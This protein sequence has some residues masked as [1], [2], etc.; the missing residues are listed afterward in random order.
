MRATW[1][2]IVLWTVDSGVARKCALAPRE[3][4]MMSEAF[5]IQVESV[6]F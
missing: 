6:Q 1:G 2:R 4:A 3:S 5:F